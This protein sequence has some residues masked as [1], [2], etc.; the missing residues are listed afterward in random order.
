MQLF[1]FFITL[2]SPYILISEE[3]KMFYQ[4]KYETALS[5]SEKK[6][7]EHAKTS[8][9]KAGNLQ[10]NLTGK[11]FKETEKS[12]EWR[13]TNLSKYHLMSDI[14][15]I[16]YYHLLNNLCNLPKASHLHVGLLAGDSYIAA[17]FGN[18]SKMAQ[19]IGVDWFKECSEEIL[20]ANCNQYLDPIQYQVINKGCFDV[21]I[22][23]FKIPINIF[24]YD[25]D[26][27]VKAHEKAF[28]YYDEAFA[29]VFIAVI[30]DWQCPWTRI[31]TFK[32]FR[33]LKYQILYENA[34]TKRDLDNQIQ[35]IVVI[36]KSSS[37][38]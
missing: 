20:R 11:E 35:Y 34:F 8:F 4:T 25:A 33:K 24:F 15:K 36:R 14:P 3:T 29:N 17:L 6:W 1:L 31:A 21:N 23:Q 13:S 26:H 28:T 7:V 12:E 16:P 2:F 5:A 18:Q 38:K 37:K 30:D 19:Q 9:E 27:S 22:S 32:A 10:S